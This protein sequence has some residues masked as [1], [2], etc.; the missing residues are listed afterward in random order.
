[1]VM[2][3]SGWSLDDIP[4]DRFDPHRVDPEMLK[5]VKAASL[6]EYNGDDYADYLCRVFHDDPAFQEAA[7]RWAG[8]EVQ[9]GLALGR[10]ARLADPNFDFEGSFRRFLEGYQLPQD[11][12]ESVRG[13]RSGEL[14]ARCI[15][16]VG[17]SSYYTAL[18]EACEE[19]VLRAIC[20]RIAADE[21]RHYRLF[22]THLK[23]YL[24]TENIGR[25]RRVIVAL[26]RIGET[27]DDELAYAYYAA[28][29]APGTPYERKRWSRAY[30]ARAFR[31]YRRAHVERGV[32]MVFKA[33]GL[34]PQSPLA[35]LVS[36]AGY[37]ILRVRGRYVRDLAKA[38]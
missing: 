25:W 35:R 27:E 1:M 12:A 17:T 30:G 26:G 14:V 8:E 3:T 36:R 15:V 22:L 23:R 19:P 2:S 33:A 18:G 28:N 34:D 6:V 31:Y 20:R 21:F 7:M 37:G 10:W 32:A 5:V 13:S 11:T 29:A 9:H 16:E 4:W 38:A 24:E